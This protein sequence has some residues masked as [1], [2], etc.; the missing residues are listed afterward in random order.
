MIHEL[1]WNSGWNNID[2]RNINNSE[3]PC[4]SATLS[5]T[6]P[7]LGMKQGLNSD[8]L[9]TNH[10]SHGMASSAHLALLE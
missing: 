2:R 10:L 6:N 3:K 5:I 7:S 8:K 9:K 1:I 4:P